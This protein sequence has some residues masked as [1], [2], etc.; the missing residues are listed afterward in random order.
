MIVYAASSD[1]GTWLNATPPTNAASLLRSASLRVAR[2]CMRDPYTDQ[3]GPTETQPLN[4]ATCAQAA[5]WIAL[6]IDPVKLGLDPGLAPVK[7]STILGAE[8]VRDTTGQTAALIEAATCLC[9]EANAI[10]TTAGLINLDLPVWTDPSDRLL[11]YGLGDRRP[12]WDGYT[13]NL[14]WFF[15]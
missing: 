15:Q 13:G 12:W 7:S 11:D 8:V 1:L 3:P 14:D 4:D 2:A 10:L 5:S 9:A 6:G